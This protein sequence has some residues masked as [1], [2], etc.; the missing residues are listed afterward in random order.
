[1]DAPAKGSWSAS[2][3]GPSGRDWFFCSSRHAALE[4]LRYPTRPGIKS[5]T[6]NARR[7]WLGLS[8]QA[9]T[10]KSQFST[11]CR[12]TRCAGRR[13]GRP[14]SRCPPAL[15]WASRCPAAPTHPLMDGG[16]V[17]TPAPAGTQI[18][19]GGIGGWSP[20]ARLAH[21]QNGCSHLEAQVQYNMGTF[22]P[23]PPPPS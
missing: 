4:Y 21:R 8:S 1:M 18:D 19:Q 2:A 23:P 16:R 15:P 12:A 20:P 11:G 14:P 6:A 13:E 22:L 17:S 3:K 7:G 5:Q 10:T 9:S